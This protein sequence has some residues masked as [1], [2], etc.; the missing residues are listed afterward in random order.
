M[1]ASSRLWL[2]EYVQNSEAT[3]GDSNCCIESH[4]HSYKSCTHNVELTRTSVA[5]IS[6]VARWFAPLYACVVRPWQCCKTCRIWSCNVVLPL[7]VTC[8]LVY[9]PRTSK[10]L[11]RP[12]LTFKIHGCCCTNTSWSASELTSVYTPKLTCEHT[13]DGSRDPTF[14]VCPIA[15]THVPS[16]DHLTTGTMLALHR[17]IL[18]FVALRT[19]QDVSHIARSIAYHCTTHG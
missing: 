1:V 7:H 4:E 5:R 9:I 17:T 2:F 18:A 10:L 8:P 6:T 11:F 13:H 3:L 16:S 15:L 14:A 12:D 19:H